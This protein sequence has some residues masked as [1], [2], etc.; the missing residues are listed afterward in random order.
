MSTKSTQR[1]GGHR[2]PRAGYTAQ[3]AGIN[4]PFARDLVARLDL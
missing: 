4:R 1:V 3:G 2:P